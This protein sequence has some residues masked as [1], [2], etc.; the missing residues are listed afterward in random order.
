M[1]NLADEL[2]EVL[3]LDIPDQEGLREPLRG[4]TVLIVVG[5]MLAELAAM[6]PALFAAIG[7]HDDLM[8]LEHAVLGPLILG[9]VSF[10]FAWLYRPCLRW[11]VRR[12]AREM[13]GIG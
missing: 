7:A 1:R 4:S 9:V 2:R 3:E 12:R 13:F 10:L 5:L 8:S 11:T 6:S